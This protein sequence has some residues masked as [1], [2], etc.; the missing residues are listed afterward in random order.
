MIFNNI[1]NTHIYVHSHKN[2]YLRFLISQSSTKD[3]VERK[4]LQGDNCNFVVENNVIIYSDSRQS[5]SVISKQCEIWKPVVGERMS[6]YNSYKSLHQIASSRRNFTLRPRYKSSV[7]F[8]TRRRESSICSRDFIFF[9]LTSLSIY[10][11][12]Q[13]VGVGDALRYWLPLMTLAHFPLCLRNR[14]GLLLGVEKKLLLQY[15]GELH[16]VLSKRGHLALRID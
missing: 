1:L 7:I 3:S 16:L 14:Q 11:L 12:C 8:N 5:V 9:H 6:S 13:C 15:C 4:I 10:S 2:S